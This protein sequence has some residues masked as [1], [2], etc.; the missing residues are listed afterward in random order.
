MQL[1]STASTYADQEQPTYL[2][3]DDYDSLRRWL[4][5]CPVADTMSAWSMTLQRRVFLQIRCKRWGC[6]HCGPRRIA[7]LTRKCCDAKPT[8]FVTLTVAN[9]LYADPREAYDKTRRHVGTLSRSIRKITD[10]WEY[11][12]VLEVTRKGWPH[13]HLIARGGWVDQSWLSSTWRSLTGAPIV[14]IRRVRKQADAAKYIM[15]YLYKQK[16]VPWTNRRVS[17]S[18][19]F[20]AKSRDPPPPSLQLEDVH[21]EGW[22]PASY[23]SFYHPDHELERIGPDMWAVT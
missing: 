19:N 1:E 21:R 2:I 18:R 22:W 5:C 15:K 4:N 23:F 7:H 12:R 20:F 9:N 8:K 11:L 14:D 10:E 17:W 13:Y 6:P 3:S 16:A